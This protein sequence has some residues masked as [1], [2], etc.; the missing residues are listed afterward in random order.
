M[1]NGKGSSTAWQK[2]ALSHLDALYGFAMVLSR[3]PIEAQDL[4]Q[5]TYTQAAPHFAKLRPESNLKGWLFTI[6][7]NAWLKELRHVRSGPDFVALDQAEVKEK[8]VD[9]DDPQALYIRIWQ[10]EEIRV[11]LE[12]LPS[13]CSE[14]IVLHDIEGFTYKEIAEILD[15]P[16]GTV[17]SRLARARARLKR[18]LCI[19]LTPVQRKNA[20]ISGS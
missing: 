5:E 15:C 9:A 6:M 3:N 2:A 12:Q 13:Y 8:A 1:S 18:V 7:R 11:A 17:M 14:I 4:V 10:R 20:A 16:I 19:R